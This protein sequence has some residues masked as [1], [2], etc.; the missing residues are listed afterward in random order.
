MKIFVPVKRVPDYEAKI[1]IKPDGS[2]VVTEGIK[3]IVNPFDEIAVEEALRIKEAGKAEEVVVVGIGP[4]D[5]A[6]QL[7]YAMAMGADRAVLIK[8]EGDVDSDLASRLLAAA[9]KRADYGLI[10]MGKQAI[11]SD[12]GQTGQLLAARLNL[13]QACFASE[14]ELDDDAATVTREIDGGLEKIK[15]PLPAVI[16]ADLRLNEPRYA[17]LPGIMKAKKKP[18]EIIDASELGVELKT[19]ISV[20]SM[21]PPEQRKAGR[22][23]ESVQELVKA[24]SEEAK[25]L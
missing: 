1:K 16:T 22:K 2:G 5:I 7:R 12:A 8:Y 3:W 11:D 20:V 10:I 24:L 17:P 6:P 23:V 21:R 9:Y 25:V 13:P 15:I 18:M 14:I 19:V 4:E